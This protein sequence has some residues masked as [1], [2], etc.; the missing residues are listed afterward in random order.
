MNRQEV[1]GIINSNIADNTS[2]DIT[3]E[4]VR[5][6]FAGALDYAEEIGGGGSGLPA[7]GAKGEAIIK[8]SSSAG[9]VKYQRVGRI[10]EVDKYSGASDSEKILAAV[11]DSLDGDTILF[12]GRAYDITRNVIV[13]KSIKFKGVSGTVLKRVNAPAI[14]LAASATSASTSIVVSD[15]TKFYTGAKI[16]VVLGKAY[17]HK[18]NSVY[19]S[20][21]SGNTLTLTAALG[22]TGDSA[23]N[24]PVGTT[25]I[26]ANTFFSGLD[27]S[28]DAFKYSWS[29]EDIIFDGNRDN[30]ELTYA[31]NI[32]NF[33][34]SYSPCAVRNC[35]FI[36]S[37]GE[38]LS[39]HNFSVENCSFK[40]LN[41]SALHLSY[42]ASY[43]N[44]GR[45]QSVF[46]GN[47]VENSNEITTLKEGTGHSEG[48][49]TSSN[50]GGYSVIANNRFINLGE[51]V[52]GGVYGPQHANDW[53]TNNLIIVGNLVRGAK[54]IAYNAFGAPKNVFIARNLLFDLAGKVDI[55]LLV[56]DGSVY[57][58]ETTVTNGGGGGDAWNFRGDWNNTTEYKVG[59]LIDF[60][61]QKSLFLCIQDNIGI[62]PEDTIRWV[63]IY[64]GR[65]FLTTN[66]QQDITGTKNFMS[67]FVLK[68]GFINAEALQNAGGG[69]GNIVVSTGPTGTLYFRKQ[70]EFV[71]DI[72]LN[73][74]Q[75]KLVSGTNIKTINNT[76]ILGSGNINIE[77]GGDAP[78]NM[79][80]TDGEGQVIG[81][82]KH[83]SNG[84]YMRELKTFLGVSAGTGGS[85][86]EKNYARFF[87]HPNK[88]AVA[89]AFNAYWD[90]VN[91]KYVMGSHSTGKAAIMEIS[92]YGC[93]I[94]YADGGDISALDAVF[95]I[96]TNGRYEVKNMKFTGLTNP[97]SG[98]LRFLR[99]G[100]DGTSYFRS[101]SETKAE[102]GINDKQDKLVSGTNIKTINGQPIIGSGDL[103]LT[104]NIVEKSSDFN[105]S[106]V[107][108]NSTLYVSHEANITVSLGSHDILGCEIE[109]INSSSSSAVS[110]TGS[111]PS[112]TFLS[113]DDKTSI[114]PKGRAKLILISKPN[115]T[116]RVWHISGDLD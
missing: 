108:D 39:G 84:S 5:T 58:E 106:G 90:T 23:S 62:H 14:T 8:N 34:S 74:K 72:G 65:T 26:L 102:L 37:P 22:V 24:Y 111:V 44:E 56:N 46:V 29:F 61:L 48:A 92:P 40:D 76:P 97:G 52:F 91:Q 10:L 45:L 105:V 66:T 19:V 43:G 18:S 81:A 35:S 9:D 75:D 104:R 33:I 21:I 1:D 20:S 83:F 28:V 3:P 110:I 116:D 27:V 114:A 54:R 60:S 68:G 25:V 13:G 30:N 115:A 95:S 55:T 2:R 15:A 69:G 4:K 107:D 77:G 49:I 101:Q 42:P 47:T 109:I 94:Y 63:R 100:G 51:A 57:I 112:V 16:C 98:G 79:V 88:S 7:G 38:A 99:L 67:G 113:V 59:D 6:A 82:Y 64:D 103:K 87:Y 36:N 32:N 50:S 80:T 41:G 71:E 78:A 31:Y 89:I 70:S 86:S 73:N 11:N 12:S 93:R 85:D 17:K 53:G 96:D